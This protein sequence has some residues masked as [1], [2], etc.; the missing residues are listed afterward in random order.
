M[1]KAAEGQTMS[2][3][4]ALRLPADHWDQLTRIQG[5]AVVVVATPI[6]KTPSVIP[7]RLVRKM[8]ASC[9]SH[10]V[11]TRAIPSLLLELQGVSVRKRQ[12]DDSL[13]PEWTGPTPLEVTDVLERKLKSL[14]PSACKNA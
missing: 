6:A 8:V 7:S 10:N 5:G 11:S 9:M 1:V 4:D 14:L 13:Q 12:V 3:K 2:L